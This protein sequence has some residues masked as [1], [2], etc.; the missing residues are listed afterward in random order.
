M[1]KRKRSTE[2]TTKEERKAA[3]SRMSLDEL[4]TNIG[5]MADDEQSVATGA[6][7]ENGGGTL[8]ESPGED[9]YEESDGTDDAE[10][11]DS[12]NGA[13]DRESSFLQHKSQLEKLKS[14]DPEFYEY[15]LQNDKDLLEFDDDGGGESDGDESAEENEENDEDNENIQGDASEDESEVDGDTGG[16]EAIEKVTMMTR[17]S[18]LEL[19]ML[20][21]KRPRE[22]LQAAKK[23]LRA[24]RSGCHLTETTKK[25]KKRK[26]GPQDDDAGAEGIS[27]GDSFG[28]EVKFASP[29]VYQRVMT[30]SVVK[31]L[32][33]LSSAA[34][35]KEGSKS[36]W[37]PSADGSRWKKVQPLIK[38]FSSSFAHL[39]EGVTDAGTTRFL[40]KRS[41]VLLPLLTPLQKQAKDLFNVV[42]EIWASEAVNVPTRLRAYLLLQVAATNFPEEYLELILKRTVKAFR[43]QIGRRCNARQLP[44]ITFSVNCIT[45][46]CGMDLSK[47]YTAAFVAIREIAVALRSALI[48]K[49]K[50]ELDK[51]Y[52]WEVVNTIRLWSRV[53]ATYPKENELRLL[54]YPLAQ[55][56]SGIM[57][58]V[59]SPRNY[60]IRFHCAQFLLDLVASSGVYIPIAPALLEVLFCKEVLK[61]T[62]STREK[63]APKKRGSKEKPRTLSDAKV[64]DWRSLLRIPDA[65]LGSRAFRD[66]AVSEA[67]YYLCVFLGTLSRC[68]AFPEVLYPT[69]ASLRTFAKEVK[70]IQY[71]KQARLLIKTADENSK[72]VQSLRSKLDFGAKGAAK[73]TCTESPLRFTKE[74]T[75]LEEL[76]DLLE[77]ERHKAQKMLDRQLLDKSAE[78]GNNLEDGADES[79]MDESDVDDE[80]REMDEAVEQPLLLRSVDEGATDDDDDVVEELELSDDE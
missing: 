3:M 70:N 52:N 1:G 15:L 11:A 74:K 32:T 75:P 57:R 23:L 49:G 71:S 64:L 78:G 38:S 26:L 39:L 40:L 12:R 35:K 27:E 6:V 54:I 80:A 62:S 19:E 30:V 21:K 77:K 59:P 17:M 4:L 65:S 76:R 33:F 67:L 8:A 69:S 73:F 14:S 10:D 43:T 50:E 16:Q 29:K 41:E 5:S 72:L 56:T 24:F 9:D 63:T 7:E 60:G 55:V 34:G 2:M 46:L 22:A 20:L 47:T 36:S 53:L 61:A 25:K 13:N 51:V 58:L 66:G 44:R 18:V 37:K 48:S 45:E 68:V 79:D 28:G 31:L 42:V